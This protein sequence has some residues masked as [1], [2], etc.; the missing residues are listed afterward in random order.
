MT[1]GFAAN[2]LDYKSLHF[3]GYIETT[4]V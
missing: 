4:H 2:E 1:G 3:I